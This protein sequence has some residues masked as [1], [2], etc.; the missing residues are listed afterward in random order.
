MSVLLPGGFLRRVLQLRFYRLHHVLVTMAVGSS[1][2]PCIELVLQLG[3]FSDRL[4]YTYYVPGL[5]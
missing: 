4:L 5:V 3:L 2:P 1:T